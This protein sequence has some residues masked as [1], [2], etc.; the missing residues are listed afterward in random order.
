ML[1]TDR[2]AGEAYDCF[3]IGSGPAGVSL[4]LALADAN[5]RV[6]VFESGAPEESE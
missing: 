3:I 5:K 2:I 4:A 1:V 6:L